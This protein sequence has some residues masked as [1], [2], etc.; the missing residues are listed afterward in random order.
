M[1]LVADILP[2]GA[3]YIWKKSE[4][5]EVLGDDAPLF[6]SFFGVEPDGNVDIIHDSHGEMRDKNILH[7]HKTYEEVALEFG[8]KEDEAKDII[9]QACEKLRL[10]REERERPGLDDKVDCLR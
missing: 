1:P 4:I 2:E 3:F 10:K 8:K 5:D 7:Q 9:V 6:N